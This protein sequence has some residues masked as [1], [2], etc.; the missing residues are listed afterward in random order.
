MSPS[1]KH[2]HLDRPKV[3]D[4]KKL[5]A[6]KLNYLAH[7]N[8]CIRNDA[9]SM[10]HNIAQKERFPVNAKDL[11]S[12]KRRVSKE[13]YN[14]FA[15]VMK[16]IAERL[17][18]SIRNV[19]TNVSGT[20]TVTYETVLTG[21][22]MMFPPDITSFDVNDAVRTLAQDVASKYKEMTEIEQS[23]LNDMCFR[24]GMYFRASG[25]R[26]F[27]KSHMPC[28]Y[29]LS[30]EGVICFTIVLH[31]CGMHILQSTKVV[32]EKLGKINALPNTG[33][34]LTATN[35]WA[36]IHISKI[37]K[38]FFKDYAAAKGIVEPMDLMD[39]SIDRKRSRIAETLKVPRAAGGKGGDDDSERPKKK[40]KKA[41]SIELP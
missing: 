18:D 41:P 3:L 29:K 40:K 34:T 24:A 31:I 10:L 30:N 39:I 22:K 15:D 35:L 25:S 14:I 8:K 9:K 11:D 6:T 19:M 32:M 2:E 5:G 36:G 26:A 21:F 4:R 12:G 7:G 33:N 17:T 13:S 37:F 28:G 38:A 1:A 27:L 16:T 23:T 20:R